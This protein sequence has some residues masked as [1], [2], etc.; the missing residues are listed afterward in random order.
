MFPNFEVLALVFQ[1][2]REEEARNQ[3]LEREH[4]QHTRR[5]ARFF[6]QVRMLLF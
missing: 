2:K 6:H 5:L 1:S 4:A 3:Y